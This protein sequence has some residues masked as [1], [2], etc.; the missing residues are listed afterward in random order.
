MKAVKRI[1]RVDAFTGTLALLACVAAAAAAVVR[2]GMLQSSDES[3]FPKPESVY[4]YYGTG[5]LEGPAMAPVTLLAYSDYTCPFCKELHGTIA[6]LMTRYP[7]HLAVVWKNID[8]TADRAL[9]NTLLGVHCAAAL[10]H[11]SEYHAAAFHQSQVVTFHRG[12]ESLA[13]TV[14]GAVSDSLRTCV[15]EQ[16]YRSRIEQDASEGAKLGISATPTFF[17][18]GR[19]V[20]GAVPAAILDAMIAFELRGANRR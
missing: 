11:F 15:L 12:W 10:G 18:N 8:N 1:F 3:G 6:E 16:R 5:L 14:F 2:S 9:L 17:V 20:D 4:S 13:A 19:R 7:H